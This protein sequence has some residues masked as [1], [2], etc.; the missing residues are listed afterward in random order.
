[1]LQGQG[2]YD[3]AEEM[4]RRALE[5]REKE[6]GLNH[7]DTLSSVY[8][9][10]YL[11]DARDEHQE[12]LALYHRASS[13]FAKVLGPKHPTTLACQ[14]HKEILLKSMRAESLSG[15]SCPSD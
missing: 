5:G 10:A 8:C 2:K 1:M 3:E 11:L 12:A 7:P 13:G 9:L 15:D 4:N 14:K 6:L